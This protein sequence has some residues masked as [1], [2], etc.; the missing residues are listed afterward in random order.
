MD[1]SKYK[2]VAEVNSAIVE[3]ALAGEAVPQ[4]LKDRLEELKAKEAAKPKE[5][6]K[7]KIEIVDSE[8]P[9][10]DTLR[11][12]Y[13]YPPYVMPEEKYKCITETV[14]HL[15]ED[16]EHAEDPCLLLGKIQCGKTDTFED[17]IGYA[18]DKKIDIAVVLTK[19]TNAL[20]AQ[21]V[22]RFQNDYAPFMQTDNAHQ[23]AVINIY[24]IK[25]VYSGLKRPQVDGKKTVIVCMKEAANMRH[26]L[27]LFK[28]NSPFLQE[29]KVLIVDDEADFASRNYQT[30]HPDVK[31]DED[32]NPI[33][34]DTEKKLAKI[35]EQIDEF[36]SIPGMYC[37]YLQVTATPY[38]LYLQPNGDLNLQGKVVKSFRPR[39]TSL[40]PIHDK[41]VGGQQYYVESQNEE[42]MF[43][44]L[45]YGVGKRCLKALKRE[46]KR[47]LKNVR[48][49][50]NIHDLRHWVMSYL[51]GTAIRCIQK[52]E[53][54]GKLYK[55]SA[56]FHLDV[57]KERHEWQEKL[58][59]A[60]IP[61][62]G[63]YFVQEQEDERFNQLFESIYADFEESNRKGREN[64]DAD[65]N[66]KPL[67]NISL[68]TRDAIKAKIKQIFEEENIVVQI[69][70]SDEN[71]SSLLNKEDGQL[72]LKAEA[73]IFIGGSILD[74]GITINNMI[75][76][77]YGRDPKTMQ[78]DTVLQHARM[79]GNRS[80]EDMAV[81][82]LYTTES[83]HQSLVRMHE[84]DEQLRQWFIDGKDKEEPNAV[85]VGFDKNIKPCAAQKI[86]VSNALAL[87]EHKMFFPMGMWTKERKAVNKI[88]K[89]IEALITSA[90]AYQ[91]NDFYEIDK[92]RAFDI[93]RLIKS[94]YLYD[95]DYDNLE[96][97]SDIDELM[98]A[99]EYCTS[100]SNDKLLVLHRK[101]R[102]MSRLRANGAF[103]DAPADG[104]TDVKTS[105]AAATTMPVLMLLEQNGK[106]MYDESKRNIGWDGTPFYWPVVMVQKDMDTVMFAIDTARK[107]QTVVIDDSDILEDIDPSEV[108]KLTFKDDMVD[109]FG[110]AGEECDVFEYRVLTENNASRY[111]QRDFFGNWE[112]SEDT[113][114]DM[115]K[116]QGV[117]TYNNGKFPFVM[118][119]Y[120]YML[121][122][123]GRNAQ[124][125][126]M[127]LELADPSEWSVHAV[128]EYNK[129]GDLV[130]YDICNGGPKKN[131][132]ILVPASDVLVN[133]SMDEKN[134]KEKN[135]CQ[136]IVGIKC[137]KVL[138]VKACEYQ[139][140]DD[141]D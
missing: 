52:L 92:D 65:G 119:P 101:G 137:K 75:S 93:L 7:K 96:R 118:R 28:E 57:N 132:E 30:V 104:N 84:L 60:I 108:L 9:I 113:E 43:R 121:L 97:K 107:K 4:E 37:R 140:D 25:E 129:D 77:F 64:K 130:E 139:F 1:V 45:F 66:L 91:L 13:P 98:C 135:V 141:E 36:R 16:G 123:Q 58:I 112:I 15:L 61:N 47:Y 116:Y 95:A 33:V 79:Y 120:K 19:G 44:H 48:E 87:K 68:P 76:F 38:C 56:L 85:F 29:K 31:N 80:M 11:T 40:V 115:D 110:N 12:N 22:I 99:L 27:E 122:R 133:K 70:N 134:Y 14:D 111:I 21:T 51:V 81:T 131:A 67:L 126:V 55:T 71:L 53:N 5:G 88:M 46:D 83:L 26:L 106:K 8:Y 50:M 20:A 90:P 103:I 42:S 10:W 94:T 49:S 127:L 74:R 69:V 86:Q 100:K 59:N 109:H 82:R 136:W 62:I 117:Y 125:S 128:A 2:T 63:E 6:G 105:K 89:E 54:E 34:Q 39:F 32:G 102:N 73:N 18:F 23:K 72:K 41:Y 35:A 114:V 17:I 24:N 78:Q 124:S 3:F 138:K